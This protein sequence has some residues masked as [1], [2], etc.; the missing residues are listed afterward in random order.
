METQALIKRE[1]TVVED[2][3]RSVTATEER[4]LKIEASLSINCLCA[5][6]PY[7]VYSDDLMFFAYNTRRKEIAE[8]SLLNVS[9]TN[10]VDHISQYSK[11]TAENIVEYFRIKKTSRNFVFSTERQFEI[12][13]LER[14]KQYVV[15]I[16]KLIEVLSNK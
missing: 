7:V 16:N 3:K 4:I 2:L 11:K 13:L 5:E 9:M 10:N 15:E 12:I 8:G 6:Y 14:E 1:T